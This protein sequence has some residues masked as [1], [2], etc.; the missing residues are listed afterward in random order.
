MFKN[1]V[2]IKLRFKYFLFLNNIDMYVE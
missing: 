1:F 2:L